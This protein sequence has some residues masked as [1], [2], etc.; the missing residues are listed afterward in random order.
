MGASSESSGGLRHVIPFSTRVHVEQLADWLSTRSKRRRVPYCSLSLDLYQPTMSSP[1]DSTS[2]LCR[3]R[4]AADR[5]DDR[6]AGD[7]PETANTNTKRLRSVVKDKELCAA[8][9]DNSRKGNA[10]KMSTHEINLDIFS[11]VASFFDAVAGDALMSLLIA[12][13]PTDARK[14]RRDYLRNNDAYLVKSLRLCKNAMPPAT[15]IAT[16]TSATILNLY[17]QAIGYFDKCRDNVLAWMDV[18][19]GWQSRCSTTNIVRYKTL[20]MEAN[21]VFNNPVVAIEL[22]LREVYSHLV[23]EKHVD[24]CD[25]DYRGFNTDALS[26]R[27]MDNDVFNQVIVALYRGDNDILQ[28]LLSSHTFHTRA[29][30]SSKLRVLNEKRILNFCHSEERRKIRHDV[31]KTLVSSPKIDVTG[32]PGYMCLYNLVINLYWR[33][34]SR[35]ESVHDEYL[36]DFASKICALLDAGA[37]AVLSP[38]DANSALTVVRNERNALYNRTKFEELSDEETARLNLWNTI[39]EKM[40]EQDNP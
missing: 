4:S 33:S 11:K 22:G 37:R 31:F 8:D 12:V 23:N 3:K 26:Y 7:S 28:T 20:R 39:L 16:A 15:R 27:G 35:M 34:Y 9:D 38:N 5:V 19:P 36:T 2:D 1:N 32:T 30:A 14:I 17:L 29:T 18:N 21:L 25:T 40:E 10:K 24:V 6:S 13:G